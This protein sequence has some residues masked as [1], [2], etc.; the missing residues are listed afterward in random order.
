MENK[1]V[2]NKIKKKKKKNKEVYKNYLQGL[3]KIE[4]GTA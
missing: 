4:N 1:E 2:Y 3:A